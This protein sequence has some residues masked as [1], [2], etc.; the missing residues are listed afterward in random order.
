MELI[1]AQSRC[2]WQNYFMRR[3]L[4]FV[5]SIL[6]GIA[7][8]LFY[9]RIIQPVEYTNTPLSSLKIDYKTDYVLMI[10]ETF[11]L[12]NDP[13][14]AIS[15]LSELDTLPT[16]E[17]IRQAILYAE[18]SGYNDTDL[19]R[20]RKLQSAIEKIAPAGTLLIP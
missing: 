3:W 4:F 16:L 19:Q 13:A 7:I 14:A 15:R 12:E 11:A 17:I 18:Q 1:L 2:L 8:G 20:M 5:L 6:I 9:G 10:S